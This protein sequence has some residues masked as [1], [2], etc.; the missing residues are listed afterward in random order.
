MLRTG[1]AGVDAARVDAT[2]PQAGASKLA[3][4]ARFA[5]SSREAEAALSTYD[6]TNVFF[7]FR[8]CA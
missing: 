7:F 2:D 5:C 3:S 1:T 4:H 8:A 6:G